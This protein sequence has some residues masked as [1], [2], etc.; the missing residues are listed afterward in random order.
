MVSI[1]TDYYKFCHSQNIFTPNLIYHMKLATTLFTV[2]LLTSATAQEKIEKW[3]YWMRP[4]NAI[5]HY[6][7]TTNKT[8][9][10][11]QQM[12]YYA[13]DWT[14]AFSTLY[15]DEARKIQNGRRQDFHRN[16]MIKAQ[17][18]FKNGN[19]EG[20]W[21]RYH[22]NGMMADSAFYING[23]VRGVRLGWNKDGYQI[24]SSYFDENGNGTIIHWYS[25]GPVSMI[26]YMVLD[27]FRTGKWKH[28]DR[29]G[30][31]KAEELYQAGKLLMS[32]CYDS[33]GVQLGK[34]ACEEREAE[35]KGGSAGW[36]RFLQ[37]NLNPDVP[38]RLRAPVGSYTVLVRFVVNTDGSLS[39]IEADTKFGF[40]MEE[41][42]IRLMKKSPAWVPALQFGRPVRAY[43]LQ[44][45]TFAVSE[46]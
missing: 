43:R 26:G 9:S 13:P 19:K 12:G 15:S 36:S 21:L 40:G 22:N 38:V 6:A 1:L 34:D 42:V 24:D 44:P 45:I 5:P 32:A 4:T 17:G 23:K 25:N 11:W 2:L 27:T 3:D 39:D 18:M 37:K 20:A 14:I 8:D 41:E 29:N 16:G 33:N 28:F 35:F 31:L 7:T 30:K 10:G 46:M